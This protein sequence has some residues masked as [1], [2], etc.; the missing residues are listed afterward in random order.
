MAASYA[1]DIIPILLSTSSNKKLDPVI[2]ASSIS[3][4]GSLL[5]LTGF[6]LHDIQV[7]FLDFV[8]Q[9]PYFF[10]IISRIIAHMI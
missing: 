5:P 3:A 8:L 6:F 4:A 9:C 7:K 1:K 10:V 2:A